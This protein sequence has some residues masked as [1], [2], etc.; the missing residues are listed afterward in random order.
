MLDDMRRDVEAEL[1]SDVLPPLGDKTFNATAVYTE[2]GFPYRALRGW[3]IVPFNKAIRPTTAGAIPLGNAALPCCPL[4]RG[5][6][7]DVLIWGM[8]ARA[9]SS[10]L[11][12]SRE[13]LRR[14]RGRCTRCGYPLG[15]LSPGSPCPECGDRL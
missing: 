15:G 1:E 5:F 2:S 14:R 13:W 10:L 9:L 3:Q 7:A 6:L 4:A 12:R 11:A 8:P